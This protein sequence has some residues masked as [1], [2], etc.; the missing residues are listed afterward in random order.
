MHRNRLEEG[1]L[2]VLLRHFERINDTSA[3]RVAMLTAN[4]AGQGRAVFCAGY[5]MGNFDS[6]DSDPHFFERI[7]DALAALRPVTVCALNGSVYG[8]ATDLVLACDLRVAVKGLE[9]RMPA[10][11]LGLHYY[12]SGLQRYVSRLG[13]NAAKRAFLTGQPLT[14]EKLYEIGCVEALV[15]ADQIDD[16]AGHLVRQVASLA[17]LAAQATKRS[18]DEIARGQPDLAAMRARETLTLASEDFREGRL[19]FAEKRSPT[20]KGC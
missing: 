19:A 14:S 5:H 9:F 18:L 15:D 20:F 10:A 3:V 12:P 17:P 7:P 4:T 8:G 2:H 16:A 11:A 6:P 1:D 13:I